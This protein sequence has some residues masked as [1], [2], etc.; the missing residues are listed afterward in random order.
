MLHSPAMSALN[1]AA[2]D[3]R[4]SSSA[5]FG[6]GKMSLSILLSLVIAPG[7]KTGINLPK[8][9]PYLTSSPRSPTAASTSKQWEGA[10]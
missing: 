3:F 4:L 2:F 7:N 10:C 9:G 8:I 6:P 1:S 5:V